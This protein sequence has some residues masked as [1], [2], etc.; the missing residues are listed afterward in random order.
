MVVTKAI[1]CSTPCSNCNLPRI[2]GGALIGG[3]IDWPAVPEGLPLTLVMSLPTTFLNESAGFELPDGHF[4]SVFSY[5]P[6]GEYFLDMI[7]YHGTQEELDWLRKGY[8]RVILHR[9]GNEVSG[10]VSI[11]AMAIEI[12]DT[13]LDVNVA[14][15]GSKIGGEPGLLQDE[16][17]ALGEARFALQIYGGNFPKPDRGIF[18]LSDAVG[19]LFIDQEP[20]ANAK[21]AGTFFVQAT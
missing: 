3:V 2:G 8:T 5:Y 14:Y 12:G 16:P 21:G 10:P 7:T 13:A 11:P 1:H 15:Q 19:Y 4:I 9:E 17:L 20:T 6:Q 18:G